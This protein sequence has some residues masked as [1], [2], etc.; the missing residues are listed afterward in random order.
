ML[1]RCL[2]ISDNDIYGHRFNGYDLG[3]YLR[4]RDIDCS[5]FVWKKHGCDDYIFEIAE[6]RRGRKKAFNLAVQWNHHNSSHAM[7]FPFSYNIL[8][9]KKFIEADM[10]H[11]HLIHNL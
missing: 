6:N 1:E 10:V 4:K 3:K 2:Q 5:L 7:L 9:E 11:L 8:F